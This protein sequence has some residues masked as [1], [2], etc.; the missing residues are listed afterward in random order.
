A[1]PGPLGTEVLVALVAIVPILVS[2]HRLLG[3]RARRAWRIAAIALLIVGAGFAILAGIST[4]SSI[5]PVEDAVAATRAGVTAAQEGDGEGAAASF[6]RAREQFRVADRRVG[7]VLTLGARLLPVV[8]PNLKSVQ[9][10]VSLG[11]DLTDSARTI[12]ADVDFD[13]VQREGGGV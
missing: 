7:S 2:A 8:G 10:S 11:A 6:Q 5:S 13:D 3:S 4:A 12:A 1:V 9:A